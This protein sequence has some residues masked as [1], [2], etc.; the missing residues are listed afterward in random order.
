MS[1]PGE[2]Q[3]K[4]LDLIDGTDL[5]KVSSVCSELWRLSWDY[6]SRLWKGK[7][8]KF[9]AF[10]GAEIFGIKT[11]QQRANLVTRILLKLKV[12]YQVMERYKKKLQKKVARENRNAAKYY[13]ARKQ[14]DALKCYK[15]IRVHEQ[16]IE[17]LEKYQSSV[18]LQPKQAF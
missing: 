10:R 15:R 18:L 11:K 3:L 13:G 16:E 6:D 4:I 2:I 8:L 14:K 9:G 1:I 12:S 17:E 7:F 5:A